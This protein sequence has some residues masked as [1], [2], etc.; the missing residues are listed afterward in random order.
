MTGPIKRGKGTDVVFFVHKGY[1]DI[2]SLY[3]FTTI[4]RHSE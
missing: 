2:Y 4:E 3:I 1:G